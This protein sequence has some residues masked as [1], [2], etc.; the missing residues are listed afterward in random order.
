MF[1]VYIIESQKDGSYYIGQTSDIEKRL[2]S[3][4]SGQTRSTKGKIP[5]NVVYTEEYSNRKDAIVRE[6]FLKKQRNR[7]FYKRLIKQMP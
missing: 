4:N 1:F 7:E 5:W 6:R 2:M 3:H